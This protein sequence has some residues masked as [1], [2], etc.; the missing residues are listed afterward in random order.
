MLSTDNIH[1]LI[2]PKFALK[3]SSK[4]NVMCS[5]LKTVFSLLYT[6]KKTGA[7]VGQTK[8]QIWVL[9]VYT[10]HGQYLQFKFS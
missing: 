8:Y 2:S 5:G 4:W 1:N 10:R 7:K 3:P 9:L 6:T